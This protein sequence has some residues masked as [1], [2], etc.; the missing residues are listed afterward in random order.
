MKIVGKS[1]IK[2]KYGIFDFLVFKNQEGLEQVVVSQGKLKGAENLLCRVHSACLVGES[3]S[4]LNCDCQRELE[5]A[6][7]AISHEQKGVVIYLHHG[8]LSDLINNY[9]KMAQKNTG[10]SF[11]DASQ[12]IKDL[13]IKSVA[14]LT[15]NRKKIESLRDCGIQV[16]M[17][18]KKYAGN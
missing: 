5:E 17:Y 14:L 7:E 18:K 16:N 1:K 4:S 6:L 11:A 13:E 15:N 10:R 9:G 12:I 3:F 8:S 2:I